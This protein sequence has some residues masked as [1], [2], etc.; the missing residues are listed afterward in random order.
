MMISYDIEYVTGQLIPAFL[1]H[2]LLLPLLDRVFA[3]ARIESSRRRLLCP[4]VCPC[5][6]V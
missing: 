6:R 5:V 4:C 3:P 2:T 1:L